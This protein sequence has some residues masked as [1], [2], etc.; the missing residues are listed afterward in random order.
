MMIAANR[1]RPNIAKLLIAAG[2]DVNARD[3]SALQTW[4][5][6]HIAAAEEH[7]EVAELLI[8]NGADID[9]LTD[10]SL[11]TP[12]LL[13]AREGN[14]TMAELLISKGA[15]LTATDSGGLTVLH[16]IA[17]TD[18]IELAELPISVGA[19]INAKD[20]NLGFTPLDYAQDGEPAMIA[21]LEQHG[22][23][24]TSC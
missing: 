9:V 16:V 24:C 17:Q 5:V 23:I 4:S 8:E 14:K 6:L 3:G 12:L 1:G 2:A 11:D 19:E 15:D 7:T 21:L 18:R 22:G 10:P 20:I 13:A